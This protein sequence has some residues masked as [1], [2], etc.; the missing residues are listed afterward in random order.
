M[1]VQERLFEM[2]A[3]LR[4]QADAYAQ[5]AA[6]ATRE[7]I[8]RA[9]RQVEA[10]DSP[11]DTLTA[12]SVELNQISANYVARLVTQQAAA[13]RALVRD[14]AA[15]L[16][17]LAKADSLAQAW[18]AQRAR[19]ADTRTQAVKHLRRSWELTADTGRA[20]GELATTTYR[21][22][23][24]PGTPPRRARHA[25]AAG[26]KTAPRKARPARRAAAARRP[27]TSARTR[28]TARPAAPVE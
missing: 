23:G 3:R 21:S 2:S 13:S 15:G 26:S 14:G 4:E 19:L 6:A 7:S 11:L 16:R 10:L 12:A 18:Q 24:L 25:R 1:T 5:R 20:V 9:A 27:A 17:S 22:L 8:D 28:K